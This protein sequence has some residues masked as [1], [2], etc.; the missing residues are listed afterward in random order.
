MKNLISPEFDLEL[1]QVRLN[2]V[3]T[4]TYPETNTFNQ[5]TNLTSNNCGL[6]LAMTSSLSGN[7]VNLDVNIKFVDNYT[8]DLRLVVYVLENHLHYT[9]RNYTTYYD[10]VNPIP[11]FEHNHV[12]RTSF[13]NLLGDL[14]TEGTGFGQSVTKHFSLPVPENVENGENIS[15]VAFV[16]G[17]G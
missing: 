3:T 2:R 13:T 14:I 17:S 16:V 4:W 12:L 10:A 6:G 7:T 11:N 1:P 8:E 5:V 9:Q 15:F